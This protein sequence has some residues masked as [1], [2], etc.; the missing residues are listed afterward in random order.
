MNKTFQNNKFYQNKS[1][2]INDKTIDASIDIL[3]VEENIY[4]LNIEFELLK[5]ESI[6]SLYLKIDSIYDFVSCVYDWENFKVNSVLVN[7]FQSWSKAYEY[8]INE[9]QTNIR[10]KPSLLRFIKSDYENWYVSKKSFL[11]NFFICFFERLPSNKNVTFISKDT[12]FPATFVFGKRENELKILFGYNGEKLEGKIKIDNIYIIFADELLQQKKS[13]ETI[14]K[15]NFELLKQKIKSKKI[16]DENSEHLYGWESWYNYYTS[17]TEDSINKNLNLFSNFIKPFNIK[18]KAVFQI[19]DGWEI[20]VGN[21]QQNEKFPT[22]LEKIAEKIEN[23]GYIPGIW[24]APLALLRES[25][26]YKNHYDWVL[27]D[28]KNQPI[29][30]G[31]IPL[32]GGDFYTYDLSIPQT[33]EYIIYQIKKL[34]EDYNFKFLKLDFLYA[35]LVNGNH[36]NKEHGTAYYYNLFQ[37]K[38]LNSLPEDIILLGCGA[39]LQLSYPFY[40]I[41]RIGADTREEWELLIGKIA[42]YEGRPSAYMSL[43]DTINRSLLNKTVYFSDPDVCF[44]RNSKIKLTYKEKLLLII[45]NFIFGSQFMISD[46]CDD[47][48]NNLIDEALYWFSQLKNRGF[49]SRRLLKKDFYFAFDKEKSILLFLNLS[50]KDIVLKNNFIQKIL[51]INLKN[52]KILFYSLK[53]IRFKENM[54]KDIDNLV[55]VEKHNFLIFEHK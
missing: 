32:W 43:T 17:I 2:Y 53:N 18:S 10:L 40:P 8:Y 23:K 3:K 7:G 48:D 13:F 39:P 30:C 37:K 31:N 15:D 19:D 1:L 11:S 38:L 12:I 33:G 20:K 45:V 36:K 24:I 51:D 49:Y 9:N 34:V 46:D 28:Y 52:Y 16:Y 50:D 27:K 22:P 55:K 47:L 42:G 14:F 6:K 35:G 44:F 4:K 54:N 25:E 26:I 21:W 41:M 5:P 29:S